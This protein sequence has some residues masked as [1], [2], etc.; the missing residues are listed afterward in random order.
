MADFHALN[1]QIR[2]NIITIVFGI[3]LVQRTALTRQGTDSI[4][5]RKVCCSIWHQDVGST[6]FKSC[7]VWVAGGASMNRTSFSIG[8][9]SEVES[10][11]QPCFSSS[12]DHSWTGFASWQGAFSCWDIGE[13][14]FHERLNLVCSSASTPGVR[15]YAERCPQGHSALF[16]YC[17]LLPPWLCVEPLWCDSYSRWHACCYGDRGHPRGL[18][19]F[20]WAGI[21]HSSLTERRLGGGVGGVDGMS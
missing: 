16:L 7:N 12:S 5:A 11:P 14:C 18:T 15:V 19:S 13:Y 9:S 2:Q 10:A 20:S 3:R 8:W 1:A 21:D 4:R 17:T 6:S